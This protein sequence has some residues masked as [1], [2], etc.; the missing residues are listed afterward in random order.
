MTNQKNKFFTL[1]FS[2]CPGA[3]QMYMGLYKMG[4]SL[5][6]LFCGIAAVAFWMRW[7]ELLF[8]L[9]VVWCYS[10]FHT[11]N[12]RRMTE[13]AFDAVED[14]FFFEGYVDMQKKWCFEGNQRRLFGGI[15]LAAG[16]TILWKTG[17][18]LLGTVFYAPEWLW[19]LGSSIPQIIVALIILYAAIRLLKEAGGEE[20]ETKEAE[21]EES[22]EAA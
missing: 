19:R 18:N 4:V 14:R 1:V 11:H 20:A 5:M 6:G 22:G 16:G 17:M 3:G 10:F 8:I 13:E 2:C 15:L 7:E 12:L 21:Q 9:P